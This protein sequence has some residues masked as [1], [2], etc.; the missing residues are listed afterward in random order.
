MGR[1]SIGRANGG[2]VVTSN[3]T[4][5]LVVDGETGGFPTVEAETSA[6][7]AET[8]QL[9]PEYDIYPVYA[10]T[11]PPQIFDNDI[12]EV[13]LLL[14]LLV[15]SNPQEWK[16]SGSQP[17]LQPTNQASWVCTYVIRT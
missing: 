13:L 1:L 9:A 16:W 10:G 6:D 3:G 5:W 11:S 2:H 14:L 17:I 8:W 4:A 15:Q 7:G 12:L